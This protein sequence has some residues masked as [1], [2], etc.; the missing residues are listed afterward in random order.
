MNEMG[1]FKWGHNYKLLLDLIYSNF[2]ESP[3]LVLS[4]QKLLPRELFPFHLT[5]SPF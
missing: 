2:G 3:K 4:Q 5:E 1:E